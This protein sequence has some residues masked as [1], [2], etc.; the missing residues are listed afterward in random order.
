VQPK[1]REDLYLASEDVVKL[2]P[3]S[4]SIS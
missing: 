2:F 4:V 1:Y 3:K